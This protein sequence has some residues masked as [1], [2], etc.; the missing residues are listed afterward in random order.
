MQ[1]TDIEDLETDPEDKR[2]IALERGMLAHDLLVFDGKKIRPLTAATMAIMQRTKNGII[3][4][5]ASNLIFDAAAF[6][7]IHTD[8]EEN[9]RTIR[10]AAFG[11]DWPGYVLDWLEALP[12]AQSKLTR[13]APQIAGLMNDYG[14]ALTKSLE[15]PEP[16]NA[17][18]RIG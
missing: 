16:G 7:I 3:F 14:A 6:I 18:G 2:D 1:N 15:I 17:G 5:D 4:G 13:F 11:T 10:R 12:D 9:A 8:D